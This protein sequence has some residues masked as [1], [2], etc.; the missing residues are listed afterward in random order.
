MVLPQKLMP[1]GYACVSDAGSV[2][3]S[4]G[5]VKRVVVA[6]TDAVLCGYVRV[7]IW[8]LTSCVYVCVCCVV[9]KKKRDRKRKTIK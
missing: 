4:T 2:D 9:G 7:A 3:G 1:F 5:L 6:K 8:Q